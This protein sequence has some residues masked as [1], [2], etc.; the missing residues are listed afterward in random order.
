MQRLFGAPGP[1]LA[2]GLEGGGFFEVGE[3]VGE[4]DGGDAAGGGSVVGLQPGG[5][6]G[7]GGIGLLEG[8]GLFGGEFGSGHGG[9]VPA[10]QP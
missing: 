9:D 6:D 7:F 5:G 4:V 1:D 8:G 3:G 10:A 2:K